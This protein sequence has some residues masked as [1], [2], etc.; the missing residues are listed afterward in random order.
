MDYLDIFSGKTMDSSCL[1]ADGLSAKYRFA[2][3][4]SVVPEYG[5]LI[6]SPANLWGRDPGAFQ[7]CL[8]VS[9][10]FHVQMMQCSRVQVIP[11]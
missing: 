2:S 3:T 8:L 9:H 10:N 7:V 11:A 6:L 1:R 5:C 4:L